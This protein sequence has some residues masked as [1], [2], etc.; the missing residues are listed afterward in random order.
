[1]DHRGCCVYD[2]LVADDDIDSLRGQ[3]VPGP[4]GYRF[5]AVERDNGVA[6]RVRIV[7]AKGDEVAWAAGFTKHDLLRDAKRKTAAHEPGRRKARR[8]RPS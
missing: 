6:V 5:D 7:D 1:M 8:G 3:H 4:D 2:R